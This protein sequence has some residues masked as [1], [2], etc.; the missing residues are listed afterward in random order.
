MAYADFNLDSVEL[1]LGLSIRPGELF[2]DLGPLPVP[3][4]VAESLERGKRQ[5]VLVSEKARSEFIVAPILLGAG[6]SI[7]DELTIF[8][9]QRLDVDPSLGLVGECDFILALTPSVP[10]LKAPLVTILEAMKGDIEAGLGQCIAQSVAARI[11]N[12]RAGEPSK[13]VFGCVTTGDDW[14]FFRLVGTEVTLDRTRLYLVNPGDILA[15]LRAI[16]R[17]GLESK[18]DRS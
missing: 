1:A 17:L 3:A 11:F 7:P 10:R 18:R 12:E 8:S 6:E 5:A 16:F 14:Q 2:P 13:T 9:G 4:F 15:M